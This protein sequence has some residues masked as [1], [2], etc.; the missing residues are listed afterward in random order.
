MTA[1]SATSPSSTYISSND[2]IFNQPEPNYSPVALTND[3]LVISERYQQLD[4][5]KRETILDLWEADHLP[6]AIALADCG[7]YGSVHKRCKKKNK[8]Q[9]HRH[10]CHLWIDTYCGRPR[11]LMRCWL[12][13]RSPEVREARQWGIEIH[14]P[15]ESALWD[16]AAKLCRWLRDQGIH[17]AMRP[18]LSPKP[19]CESVRIIYQRER[20]FFPE[21][22]THLHKMTKHAS[23]YSAS[24]FYDASTAKVIEWMF[25]SHLAI[26]EACGH[27]RAKFY[28]QWYRRQMTKTYGDFYKEIDEEQDLSGYIEEGERRI[29]IACDCGECDGEMEVIPW[30]E[31]YTQ[32]VDEIEREYQHVDW[33]SCYDPFNNRRISHKQPL[34]TESTATRAKIDSLTP[35]PPS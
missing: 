23:G 32:S 10:T 5:H 11:N 35:S 8:A 12:R 15:L 20:S 16:R 4:P 29:E 31:R 2:P 9:A 18:V 21:I 28:I 26:L 3:G 27:I 24:T 17:C 30:N 19:R 7:R 25:S 22:T 13:W 1:A 33:T 6:A 14:G 34:M